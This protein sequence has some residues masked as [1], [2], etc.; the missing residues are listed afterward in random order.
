VIAH[1][2]HDHPCRNLVHDLHIRHTITLLYICS[3]RFVFFATQRPATELSACVPLTTSAISWP[4]KRKSMFFHIYIYIYKHY[5]KTL[6]YSPATL[7]PNC[8]AI[9]ES[10]S[11]IYVHKQTNA[12]TDSDFKKYRLTNYM[13]LSTT[14]EANSFYAKISVSLL[15]NDKE[16]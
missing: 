4:R 6:A 15:N 3:R 14:R 13:D 16:L 9:G 11:E 10:L 2:T 12:Q 5:T 8:N 7:C 1:T